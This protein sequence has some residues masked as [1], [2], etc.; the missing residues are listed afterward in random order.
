MRATIGACVVLVSL[1]WLVS[2]DALADGIKPKKARPAANK[3]QGGQPGANL[4]LLPGVQLPALP[5]LQI[6][7]LQPGLMPLRGNLNI[8]GQQQMEFDNL[9]DFMNALRNMN[10]DP[11]IVR[12]FEKA[13]QN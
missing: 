2:L 5:G 7:G 10:F 13:L 1:A 11:A 8:K 6:Q 9:D 12:F 3:F 4:P